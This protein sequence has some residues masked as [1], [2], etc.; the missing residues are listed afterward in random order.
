MVTCLSIRERFERHS[1]RSKIEISTTGFLEKHLLLLVVAAYVL[2]TFL[3]GP[4]TMIREFAFHTRLGGSGFDFKAPSLLL[5]V[6]L[7]VSGTRVK[8]DRAVQVFR[9]PA[10]LAVG[11]AL[12]LGRRSH[13]SWSARC[14]SR[15]GTTR[16]RR[17]SYSAALRL[18]R[19]CPSR[20][21]RRVGRKA[22]AATWL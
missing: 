5:A 22:P 15:P 14:S 18:L 17:A 21:H 8:A 2:A 20:V 12:N 7:F 11:L 6:L 3:P 19:R 16:T 4:G 1:M 13:T 9:R 10:V